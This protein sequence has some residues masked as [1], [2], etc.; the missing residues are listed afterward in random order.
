MQKTSSQFTKYTILSELLLAT[1]MATLPQ[2]PHLSCSNYLQTAKKK[3]KRALKQHQHF[4][5]YLSWWRLRT[6]GS[7]PSAI[8]FVLT[9]AFCFSFFKINLRFWKMPGEMRRCTMLHAIW[10][11]RLAQFT[12][13][14]S[15]SLARTISAFSHHRYVTSLLGCPSPTSFECSLRGH[16]K[17]FQQFDFFH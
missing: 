4:Y 13:C 12:T 6:L 3:K 17:S 1:L 2:L 16:L 11:K 14:T 5:T 15:G 9:F 8:M 7:P 10:W